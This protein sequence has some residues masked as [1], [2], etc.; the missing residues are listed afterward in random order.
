MENY[1]HHLATRDI[2]KEKTRECLVA[3]A[4]FAG[5]FLILFVSLISAAPQGASNIAVQ[6]NETSSN[7]AGTI[8]NISG[9]YIAT[10]NITGQSQNTRWKAFVGQV[11]GTFSLDDAS[12]A[13]IYDWTIAS[14]G[15]EVY[16]TRNATTITWTSI[17]CANTTLLETENTQMAHT[18]ADDNIT[19]TFDDTT[20]AEFFV[21][22]VNIS[23]NSCPT[24]NTYVDNST[25]DTSFEEIAL[26]DSTNFTAGGNV[27]YATIMESNLAGFDSNPYDFQMI[28]P[29]R[30]TPGFSGATAYYL[31]VELS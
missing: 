7:T 25:Q 29:E 9:G 19:A 5:L 31:Y 11:T 15:G 3:C 6:S 21:G 17:Q 12:G 27:V 24:L 8:L 14:T 16:A 13:T 18:S 20:H 10:V 2:W 22:N 4:L 23:T 26:S 28:V 30:G 1:V